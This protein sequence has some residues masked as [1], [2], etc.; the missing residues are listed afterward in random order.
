MARYEIVPHGISYSRR[1]AVRDTR[2]Y[3]IIAMGFL[4]IALAQDFVETL[5]AKD[6]AV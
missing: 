4:T 2:S 5:L 1:Y 3:H 6:A